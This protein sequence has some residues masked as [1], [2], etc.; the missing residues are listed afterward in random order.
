MSMYFFHFLKL[1]AVY[2]AVM[3]VG[4]LICDNMNEFKQSAIWT[5]VFD[6]VIFVLTAM[7]L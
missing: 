2:F 5:A 1:A 7:A 6:F 4:F 3:P